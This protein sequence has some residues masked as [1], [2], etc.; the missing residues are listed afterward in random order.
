[1]VGP[2]QIWIVANW[3]SN[4]TIKQA[5]EWIGTVGPEIE[6]RPNVKVV[7]CPTFI[8][9]EEVKKAVKVGNFPI[10]VGA[11]DLSPFE[12]GPYTGEEAAALLQDVVDLAIIGHSER[13]ANFSETDE[14]VAKKVEEALKYNI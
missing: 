12:V 1:M 9:I 14:M 13:R 8:A 11:Q 6:N 3:K 2:K 10:M 5:L 7:V 4:E